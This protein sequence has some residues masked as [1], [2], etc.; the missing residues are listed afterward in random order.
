MKRLVAAASALRVI[1]F[2]APARGDLSTVQA[3]DR[4]RDQTL[5]IVMALVQVLA[6]WAGQ[7][8]ERIEELPCC[9]G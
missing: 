6:S 7:P 1:G 9:Q 4:A 5:L 3:I 2:G 8:E